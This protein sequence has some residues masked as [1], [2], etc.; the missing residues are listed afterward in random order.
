M[1]S[2]FLPFSI[3]RPN[4]DSTSVLDPFEVLLRFYLPDQENYRIL[5]TH[6][7]EVTA[8]ALRLGKRMQESGHIIDLRFVYEAAMLHDVGIFLT[9]APGIGCHGSDPYIRH[10]YLGAILLRGLGLEAHARVCE[11]HTGTG[12]SEQ[13]IR[14]QGLPLPLERTYLPETMEEQLICYADKF[15][16]KTKLGRQKELIAVERSLSR[17][18]AD[19]TERF[20]HLVELFGHP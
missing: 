12:L 20:R 19:S 13:Y 3:P 11:R 16:S 15:F 6:S 10:G 14:E 5:C 18:G 17:F 9:N 2:S 4:E 1:E 8:L 7:I